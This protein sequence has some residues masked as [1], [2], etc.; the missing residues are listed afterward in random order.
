[1]K[2][3]IE[4]IHILLQN[5]VASCNKY[6]WYHKIS[7]FS[8]NLS[9]VLQNYSFNTKLAMFCGELT[10]LIWNQLFLKKI[11]T[12]MQNLQRLHAN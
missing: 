8:T 12:L 11:T 10:V 5:Y 6:I 9:L 7:I 3:L 2:L 4:N 1:M